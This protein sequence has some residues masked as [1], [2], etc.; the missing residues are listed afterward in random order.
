MTGTTPYFNANMPSKFPRAI[1]S[2]LQPIYAISSK[3]RH[4]EFLV[5]F[6]IVDLMRMRPFLSILVGSRAAELD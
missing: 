5:I 3:I 4:E 6:V 2:F 1:R